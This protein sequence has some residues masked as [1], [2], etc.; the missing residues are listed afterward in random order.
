[1]TIEKITKEFIKEIDNS[2]LIKELK[3][4]R[5]IV[6]S[7]EEILFLLDRIHNEDNDY[8][9][10]KLRKEI[11]SYEAY[12]EYMK[13]YS[14]VISMVKELNKMVRMFSAEKVCDL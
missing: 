10:I 2:V 4:Y 11:Y 9:V 1:M 6:K 8:E 3:Y 14:E 13:R 5:D 7:D 12:R